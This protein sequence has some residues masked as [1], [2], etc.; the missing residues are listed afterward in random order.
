MNNFIEWNS[1]NFNNKTSGEVLL[2]CPICSHTR[3][4]NTQKCLGVNLDKG[5]GRCNHCEAITVKES[6][7]KFIEKEYT[8]PSQNWRN[9]TSM[10]D[11]MVKWLKSER[12]ISQS[13]LIDLGVT[14]EKYFQ[15]SKGKELNNIVFNYF[16]GDKLVNKKYR[17]GGKDFTQTKDGKPI[18][19]ILFQWQKILVKLYR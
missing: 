5:I 14:E 3:K 9:Y 17:S 11:N 6:K 1:I 18:F 15:P 13:T 12:K 7:K 16:E 2:L 4:K 8:L 19:Q 10:S